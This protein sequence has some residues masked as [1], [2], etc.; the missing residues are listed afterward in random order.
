VVE[1]GAGQAPAVRE[2]ALQ[3]G[4]F[5]RVEVVRDHAGIERVLAVQ[6]GWGGWTRS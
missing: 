5:T 1:M 6:G 4:G 3:A 2:L